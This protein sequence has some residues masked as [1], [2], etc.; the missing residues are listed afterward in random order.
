MR[1]KNKLSLYKFKI[2]QARSRIANAQEVKNSS[3]DKPYNDFF[4]HSDFSKFYGDKKKTEARL[5][6]IQTS[7]GKT[8]KINDFHMQMLYDHQ[9]EALHWLLEQH[10]AKRGSLLGDEMGLGKTI[11]TLS[12]L[13]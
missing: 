7:N 10:S 11:I 13:S 4:C 12:L 5:F 9:I 8:Y 2:D 1:S 3:I 6:E